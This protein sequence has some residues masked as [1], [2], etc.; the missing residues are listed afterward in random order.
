MMTA[1]S[2][3][4]SSGRTTDEQLLCCP[5]IEPAPVGTDAA[6]VAGIADEL[7]AGFRALADAGPAVT[8][9]G[10]ARIP[11]SAA[12]YELARETARR[13]GAAGFSIIT[14]GG[15]GIM[16]A[17][18][19][20]ARDAG[21]TSIGC[22]IELPRE[23]AVN[24]YLDVAV[25]FKHFFVRKVMLVRYASA[26]VIFPGG[27]GTLDELAEALTLIQTGKIHN[28]PVVLMGGEHWH[29]LV[30][31]MHEH[32]LSNGLV[33]SQDLALLHVADEAVVAADLIDRLTPRAVA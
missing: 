11:G 18:N 33:G 19:R 15:P 1:T 27:F 5:W 9:F 20:G 26:F 7:M 30:D 28:F 14:G 24:P 32:L 22:T 21:V 4:G 8:V 17:A 16:E 31:W 10:S 3:G 2:D 29:G 6:W 25:E 12:A 23:Q 13:L